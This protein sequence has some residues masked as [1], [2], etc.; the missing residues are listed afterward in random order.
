MLAPSGF[1]GIDPKPTTSRSSSYAREEVV[2]FA[3]LLYCCS[4]SLYDWKNCF[5]SPGARSCENCP[6]LVGI[7]YSLA[8]IAHARE[9]VDELEDHSP[10]RVADV[11]TRIKLDYADTPRGRSLRLVHGPIVS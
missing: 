10:L 8:R 5:L 2:I 4:I 9:I 3:S 1:T 6:V 7:P 11:I